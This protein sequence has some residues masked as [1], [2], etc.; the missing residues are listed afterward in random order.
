[1]ESLVALLVFA[2]LLTYTSGYYMWWGGY[3]YA[4][5]HLIPAL[6]LLALGMVPWL[7]E[8]RRLAALLFLCVAL[9]SALLNVTAVA[10]DPQPWPGLSNEQLMAPQSV[11]HWPS[12][13][14]NLQVR[15][16]T[17]AAPD[18]NWGHALG[19]QG[20]ATLLPLATIWAI[21]GLALLLGRKPGSGRASGV[22]AHML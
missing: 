15:F 5:R 21:A 18:K 17:R 8:G 19:L 2:G 12:P 3:A 13:Y 14:L 22:P 16:W 10:V 9:G 6:P 11:G 1:M 20:R 4:P 7:R